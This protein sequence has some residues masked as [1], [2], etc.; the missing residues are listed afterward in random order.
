MGTVP[1]AEVIIQAGK[2]RF[3][4]GTSDSSC[5]LFVDALKTQ[6]RNRFENDNIQEYSQVGYWRVYKNTEN[7]KTAGYRSEEYR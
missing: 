7:S 6:N 4:C 3:F 2:I 5:W 1:L